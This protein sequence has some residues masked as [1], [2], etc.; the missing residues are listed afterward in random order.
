MGTPANH[1]LAASRWLPWAALAG[2]AALGLYLYLRSRSESSEGETREAL[3]GMIPPMPVEGAGAAA[4][5][6]Y[7]N[8]LRESLAERPQESHEA[9]Q[10]AP[11]APQGP[12]TFTPQE[13]PVKTTGLEVFRP[14]ERPPKVGVGLGAFGGAITAGP[15]PGT[16]TIP[17]I[18]GAVMPA[19]V[20]EAGH[21]TGAAAEI[22]T[23]LGGYTN[24]QY[25]QQRREAE[26]RSGR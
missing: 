19:P 14:G 21:P 6:G 15:A 3:A 1:G 9:P 2:V 24:P 8:R 16:V 25:V 23:A 4:L 10:S 22:A 12:E 13:G 26:A 18:G 17:G 7:E 5:A 20:D 11:P